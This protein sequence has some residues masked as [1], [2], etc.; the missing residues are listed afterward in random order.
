MI[1]E[2]HLLDAIRHSGVSKIA[3]IDDAFDA[4]SIDDKNAGELLEYLE[5]PEFAAIRDEVEVSEASA[6]EAITALAQSEYDSETLQGVVRAL[7]DRF[8]TTLDARFDA[9]GI[10]D[11]Q[12]ANIRNVIPI[13]NLLGKCNPPPKVFRVGSDQQGLAAV[14]QDTHLI[15][16]DFYLDPA[17]SDETGAS[18]KRSAKEK[19]LARVT[20]LVKTLG[21][22]APSVV[23][24]S[25][26]DVSKDAEKFREEIA[27]NKSLVFRSRFAFV[28]KTELLVDQ[29]GEISAEDRAGDEL[30]D[31]FQ[32]FEF[33]RST[34]AALEAWLE[35]AL[36]AAKELRK[37]IE[38][39]HLKDFAYLVRFRL[40]AD[41]Q[42]LLDY[43][44]WF[45]G[46]CLLDAVGRGVETKAEGDA[47]IGAL[48]APAAARIDGA[49]DGPTKKVAELYHRVRIENPRK[50]RKKEYRLG[51]L[52]VSG[53]GKKRVIHAVMTPDCDLVTRSSGGKPAAPRLLTV[54]GKLK[55]FDAPDASVSDFI[56]INARPNNI[57]WD[58]KEVETK[59]FEDLPPRESTEQHAFLGT[60]R[61]LYA[62][63]LQR[64]V[65]HDLGRVGLSVAPAIGMS[66]RARIFL[67]LA[68]GGTR[69][70]D[71][72]KP[73][74]ADCY[75]VPG[76]GGGDKPR[77]L[78]KR[79][80][81]SGLRSALLAA[82]SADLLASAAENI[83]KLGKNNGL[84][85]LSKKMH[86]KG[87]PYESMIEFEMFLTSKPALT[88]GEKSW[89]LLLVE[90]QT[91]E[92]E[93]E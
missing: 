30:L 91:E 72:G 24:M 89:C 76:R 56:L 74:V 53:T 21:E 67:R 85:K 70:L 57:S 36:D 59:K 1:H 10:F 86:G 5:G 29:D 93:E 78:F 26:Y 88:G 7:Y 48:N 8:S 11:A 80:F 84:A 77:V 61:P 3:I 65:L 14:E 46:E 54:S 37:D 15:F 69:E 39:L 66:A 47:R 58:E 51:D 62:Q 32:S 45:F 6:T 23:L 41:G 31:I 63:Q 49:F 34:H 16:V 13:L 22:N 2:G 38:H 33:G 9:G 55:S 20:E 4:P 44:E 73:N 40:A 75:I 82:Q 71:I 27:D 17:V 92:A 64:N 50:N 18:R 35:S 28:Q 19:A 52:Y 79:G 87:I 68:G 90:M 83:E 43:L 25:S 81:A 42:G 60:L 12:S